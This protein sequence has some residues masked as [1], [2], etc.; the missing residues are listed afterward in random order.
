MTRAGGTVALTHEGPITAT[1]GSLDTPQVTAS[2]GRVAWTGKVA[3]KLAGDGSLTGD[4]DGSLRTENAVVRLVALAL[5]LRYE[6]LI[7]EGTTSIAGTADGAVT[8]RTAGRTSIESIVQTDEGRGLEIISVEK[9]AV[10]GVQ[11]T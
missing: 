9:V 5:S 6:S 8:S 10:E 1:G 11:G 2:E 3:A 4:L 7:F